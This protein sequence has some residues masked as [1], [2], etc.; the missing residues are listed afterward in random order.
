MIK[1]GNHGDDVRSDCLVSLEIRES[2]GLDIVIRSKVG[3]MYEDNIRDLC[4]EV[5]IF[6]GIEHAHV[7]IDDTGA[8]PYV[9]AARIETA[10]KR[11]RPDID[12]E[13]LPEMADT[14]RYKSKPDRL[15]R[16]RLYLPGNTPKFAINAGLHNPD[17][18]ILDLEDS[19]APSEK[20]A[21]RIL[22]RNT[23]RCVD[24]YGSERMVRIN[25]IPM[26]LKDLRYIIPHNVH[27]VLI[28]KCETADQVHQV[29][30]AIAEIA[31]QCNRFEPVYLMPIIESALGV[32]NAYDIAAA[33]ENNVALTIGLQDYTAD[34]GAEKTKEGHESYF[35]RCQV[36]NAARA[37]RLQ[38]IDTVFADVGDEEGLIQ[39]VLEAKSLGYEGKGCI[40]PRQ[41]KTIHETFAP[42][43]EELDKA[44]KI[45]EA[46]E[47]AQKKGS[48]VTVLGT[49]MI[50]PPVVKRAQ[51]VLKLSEA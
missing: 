4:R 16:S 11:A 40:H 39:S 9:L 37:A 28:P 49:K 20:D 31:S 46:F 41:I 42:T 44:R 3:V 33:S 17:G 15:R 50:D 36:V 7:E 25:Q 18:A 1:A 47:E 23:L 14:C 8:L 19:V 13:Y 34:I 2:G 10:V 5:M 38:P 43:P 6:L 29:D 24:F 35:A 48:S 22:V 26:G 30:A 27:L 12:K 45:V 51:R 32:V 21:A